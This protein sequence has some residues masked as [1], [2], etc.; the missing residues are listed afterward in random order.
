VRRELGDGFELDDDPER[1]D[2]DAVSEFLSKH[3]Y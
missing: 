1:I 2:V 3:A